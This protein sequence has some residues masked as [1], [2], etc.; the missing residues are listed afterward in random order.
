MVKNARE[1]EAAKEDEMRRNLEAKNEMELDKKAQ[2]SERAAAAAAKAAEQARNVA[3]FE[4]QTVKAKLEAEAAERQVNMLRME[5]MELARAV[6]QREMQNRILQQLEADNWSGTMGLPGDLMAP[7]LLTQQD[8]V[9]LG[10][11]KQKNMIRERLLPLVTQS[12]PHHGKRITEVRASE[13]AKRV[14]KSGLWQARHPPSEAL[15][16]QCTNALELASLAPRYSSTLSK[17]T[18]SLSCS[19]RPT[20]CCTRSPRP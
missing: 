15:A 14:Q 11:E 6:Q 5:E 8:M 18:I 17:Y 3:E 7:A 10:V 9:G 1:K 4:H 2:A 16:E 20:I 19:A 12:Q 13:R